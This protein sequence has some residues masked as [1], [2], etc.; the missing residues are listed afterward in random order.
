MTKEER[1]WRYVAEFLHGRLQIDSRKTGREVDSIFAYYERALESVE[2]E[3][4][5]K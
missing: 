2:K 3:T 1:A 5:D 4:V